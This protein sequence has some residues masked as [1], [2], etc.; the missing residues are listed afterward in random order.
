VVIPQ[1]I[2]AVNRPHETVAAITGQ[3]QAYR[4]ARCCES[5]APIAWIPRAAR[6]KFK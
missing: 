2:A 6:A 5:A 4:T 3:A 1:T